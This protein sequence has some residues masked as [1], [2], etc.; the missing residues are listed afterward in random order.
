MKKLI[1]LLT[2]KNHSTGLLLI[3]L[4]LCG[5]L[6][7][8][9]TTP[10]MQTIRHLPQI[11]IKDEGY[12]TFLKNTA[13]NLLNKEYRSSIE[14]TIKNLIVF[15]HGSTAIQPMGFST[16]DISII[17]LQTMKGAVSHSADG[18]M[19]LGH[20]LVTHE[21]VNPDQRSQLCNDNI[22]FESYL[23]TATIRTMRTTTSILYEMKRKG[24]NQQFTISRVALRRE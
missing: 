24:F 11:G 1:F 19:E 12:A 18:S 3:S 16:R 17:P 7:A 8:L 6:F 23:V 10:P 21:S 5:R 2:F 20:C 9:D 13:W 4:V 22:D 15:D 14:E